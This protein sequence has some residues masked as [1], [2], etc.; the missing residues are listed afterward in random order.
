MMRFLRRLLEP[1]L[2]LAANLRWN[3]RTLRAL[4]DAPLYILHSYNQFPAAYLKSRRV[5]SPYIYDAHDSYWEEDPSLDTLFRAR[6]TRRL[7]ERMEGACARRAAQVVTVSDGV[8]ALLERRFGRRPTVVRNAAD[9]R[10]DA[11]SP[12]DVRS[13]AGLGGD[14]FLLVMPGNAKPG[15]TIEEALEALAA[16]PGRVH[17]ALVGNGHE[18]FAARA[19]E[20]GVADRVHLLPPVPP[21]EVAS[22]IA[23]ADAAPILYRAWTVN[24]LHALPN[25]FYHAVAAGLPILYPP[26]VEI[27]ALCEEHRMGVPI[28]PADPASVAAAVTRLLDDP[29]LLAELAANVERA[30]EALSW[31]HEEQVLAGLLDSELPRGGDG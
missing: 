24:F 21:T 13:A 19:G 17:L 29:D 26:L 6:L 15:D 31:E 5:G 20:R 1:P 9:A 7:F 2:A 3:L 10:L 12:S 30:R 22:F 16:L 25:R 14:A 27:A 28:D 8:A 18:A 4:P 11:P 23:T